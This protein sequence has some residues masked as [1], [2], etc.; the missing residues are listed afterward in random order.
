MYIFISSTFVDLRAERAKVIEAI[1]K[2]EALPWGMEFFV[3][4]PDQP[5]ALCL[6]ELDRCNAVILLIGSK[7]GSLVPNATGLTYTEAEI[8]RARTRG[9]P[10]FTFM[11]TVGARLPNDHDP[12]DPLHAKLNSFRDAASKIGAPGY[13]ETVDELATDVLAIATRWEKAGRPGARRIFAAPNDFFDL[14][15]PPQKLLRHDVLLYGRSKEVEELNAFDRQDAAVL[16]L[17]AEGGTGK[18]K[19]LHDWT[20]T[21]THRSVLFVKPGALWHGEAARELPDG[22][23]LIA[24]DDAHQEPLLVESVALLLREVRQRRDAKLVVATRPRGA[25]QVR[26]AITRRF[27]SEEVRSLRLSPLTLDDRRRIAEAVLQPDYVHLRDHLVEVAG[28]SPLVLVVAG[29]II[30]SGEVDPAALLAAPRFSEEI[31]NRFVEELGSEADA[32][33]PLLN[34]LALVGPVHTHAE[35]FLAPAGGVLGLPPDEIHRGVRVLEARGLIGRRGSAI[36]VIPDVLA[37]RLVRVASAEDIGQPTG[38][39]D[40]VYE[41]FGLAY[42]ENLLASVAELTWRLSQEGYPSPLLDRIWADLRQ[43]AADSSWHRREVLKAVRAAAVYQPDQAFEF[44]QAASELGLERWEHDEVAEIVRVAAYH[45]CYTTH[46]FDELWPRAIADE[47]P[48]NAYPSHAARL[49]SELAGYAP[50]KSV[51]FSE[52]IL[53][54]ARSRMREAGAFSRRFT[55]L[56]LAD[57]VLEREGEIHEGTETGITLR[58]AALNH[59]VVQPL[60]SRAI[61]MVRE[62]LFMSEP[63]AQMRAVKSVSTI[64]HGFSPAFG[65]PQSDEE[66][67]WQDAERLQMLDIVDERLRGTPSTAL[68]FAAHAGIERGSWG[69]RR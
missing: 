27:S 39:V 38:Y 66:L 36:R 62:A 59:K 45:P 15:T 44:A 41:A 31:L 35:T 33:R 56:D 1:Q 34:L 19:L 29:R 49:L 6:N 17:T 26:A 46:A 40:R 11:K 57:A 52:R 43:Q 65:R 30:A 32:W 42:I 64:L 8:E 18:S 24:F 7:A 22:P 20:Q 28:E 13:F 69:R 23:I 4:T 9:V 53:E 51:E 61:D 48:T 5:L 25:D 10:I 55:P 2:G 58:A 47:R 37:D 67:K 50:F 54:L 63:P 21:V 3:S 16:M 12:S 60:R 14:E 68:R